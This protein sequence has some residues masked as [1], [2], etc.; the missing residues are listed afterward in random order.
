MGHR[1]PFHG[2]KCKGFHGHRYKIELGVDD[3]VSREIGA[4]DEGMVI[5]YADMKTILMR[6]DD[7][8][9]HTSVYSSLDPMRYHLYELEKDSPKPFVWIDSIPSAESLASIW[10][11]ELKPLLKDRG[12]LI[13]YVKV[14]E[15]PNSTAIYEEETI[16][17]EEGADGSR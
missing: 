5:D 16:Q 14:W 9:D 3:I 12:I 6:I 15:T 7:K 11:Y 1:V 13:S 8:Y 10:Y 4:P 17:L 2:G